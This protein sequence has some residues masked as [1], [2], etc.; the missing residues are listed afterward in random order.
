MSGE[1]KVNVAPDEIIVQLGI[2]TFDRALE[3]AKSKNDDAAKSFIA[4]VKELGIHDKNVQTSALNVEI[5]DENGAAKRTVAGYFVRRAY[6]VTLSD[7]SMLEP[8]FESSINNGVNE[9]TNV[10]FKS[11]ALRKHRDEARRLAITAA[12]E[13]AE[14]LAEALGCN[15]GAPRTINEGSGAWGYNGYF[16][17]RWSGSAMTQN[18]VQSDGDATAAGGET[19]PLGQIGIQA[20]VNVVFDLLPNDAPTTRAAREP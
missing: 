12:R 19:T 6:S 4:G 17:S 9:L 7:V 16:G 8:L 13:K 10:D 2:S 5:I 11:T 18:V 20:S 3:S 1:A 14:A 15:L